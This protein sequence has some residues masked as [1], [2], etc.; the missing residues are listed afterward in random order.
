MH[1]RLLCMVYMQVHGS[2][3]IVRFDESCPW[4]EHLYELE[5]KMA[6][7]PNVKFVLYKELDSTKWRIQVH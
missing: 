5:E 6:V 1:T 3:E 2:G 7:N 4:K